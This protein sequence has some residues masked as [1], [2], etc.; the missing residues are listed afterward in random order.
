L[1]VGWT[2][3][4]GEIMVQKAGGAAEDWAEQGG[5]TRPWGRLLKPEE[6]AGAI[7]FLASDEAAV[8]S[9]ITIDLEQFPLGRLGGHVGK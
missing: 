8:F 4:D 5:A 6:I 7:A 9:G 2:L 1:N 3:T